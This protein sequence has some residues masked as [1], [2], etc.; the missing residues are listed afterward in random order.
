MPANVHDPDAV[1]AYMERLDHPLKAE[2]QAV[3][4]LIKGVES[5]I[6]E[7]VKWNAPS[8]SYKGYLATFNLRPTHHVHLVWHN[9]AILQDPAGLLEGRYPDRRMTYFT[10]MAE[11]EAKRPA[12]EA[13][14]RQWV[15]LM[16]Q[17]D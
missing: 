11:V 8:F 17:G 14:V 12:M 2:V 7:Q 3:R 6:T 15:E 10:S 4:D 5:R 9:G 13:L 1:D 16:D